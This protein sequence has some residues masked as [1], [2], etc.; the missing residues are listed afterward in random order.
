[1]ESGEARAAAEVLE[2]VALAL[3]GSAERL[4]KDLDRAESAARAARAALSTRAA[5]ADRLAP[6]VRGGGRRCL[7]HRRGRNRR[8]GPGGGARR[9]AE[10]GRS[11]PRPRPRRGGPRGGGRGARRLRVGPGPAV[12]PRHLPRAERSVAR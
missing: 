5:I 12:D 4:E 2:R 3:R 11:P 1:V 7:A 6:A 10:T 9:R 8:P